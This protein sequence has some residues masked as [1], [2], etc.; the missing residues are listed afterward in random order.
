[1][2]LVSIPNRA[3]VQFALRGEGRTCEEQ[4]V[5]IPNRAIVQFARVHTDGIKNPNKFQS[6]IGRSFN[7]HPLMSEFYRFPCGF[8]P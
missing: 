2:M 1:M 5:S 8:N 4:S 7:L 6:L 3:I